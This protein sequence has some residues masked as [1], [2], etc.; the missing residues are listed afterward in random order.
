MSLQL[1]ASSI[2]SVCF[3]NLNSPAVHEGGHSFA[4]LRLGWV[5]ADKQL[6]VAGFV[7]NLTDK[8]Y[9]LYAGDLASLLGYVQDL[10]DKP[11]TFALSLMCR[12]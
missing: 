3:D 7:E 5:S 8:R 1:D 4:H 6:Q 10:Y 11:R 9:R 12:F 2:S